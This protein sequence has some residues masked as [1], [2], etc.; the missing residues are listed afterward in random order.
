MNHQSHTGHNHTEHNHHDHHAH[1]VAD[2]RKRFWISLIISIPILVL[3]PMIQKFLGLAEILQFPGDMYVLFTLSSLVFFYGGYPF[4]NGLY[5]E[6]KS[7]KPGMMT[8][9]AIAISVAY[10]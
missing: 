7:A 4:L 9:I 6:L 3:S 5:T 10:I 1:M 2:F 8:L